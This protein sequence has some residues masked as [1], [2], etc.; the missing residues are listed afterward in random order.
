MPTPSVFMIGWEYPPHNSGGLGVA[1]EGLTKALAGQ[2]THIYFTLPYNHALDLDHVELIPCIDPSWESTSHPPFLAYAAARPVVTKTLLDAEELHALP[3]SELEW[4]VDQYSHL[5]AQEA[6]PRKKGIDVVHAHDWMTFPAAG[7][8]K[9]KTGKPFVAH[10][11]STEFDRIPHGT[12]SAYIHQTE[13][14]GLQQADRVIAVSNYTKQLLISKYQVSP[15]KIDVVYN[16]IEP[17]KPIA[18]STRFAQ[19][20]PVIVFMGRLTVQKG[21]DYFIQLAQQ[22]LKSV[23]NAL[24][25]VAG[26]GDMYYQLLLS[27][28]ASGLSASVLFSGFL[29]GRDRDRLLERADIFIMPSLSEPFGLVAVEAAQRHTP[30]I[31]SKT[32]GVGEVLPSAKVVDFWDTQ[33]MAATV[34]ELLQNRPQRDIQ[35]QKQL[36]DVDQVSWNTAAESVQSV[37]KKAVSL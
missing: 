33:L 28:A 16:G 8:I 6:Q 20:R 15:T 13:Y 21:A 23:P 37:Y 25:I 32:S 14:E 12:G 35:V 22:V 10:V 27:T 1:C 3:N 19:G 17:V 9:K 29:R 34:Q 26:Q 31:L 2:N 7:I 30:V 5:V 18:D 11:H 36:K 4:R 24:F